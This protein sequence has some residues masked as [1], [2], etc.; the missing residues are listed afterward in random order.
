L[1]R[2]PLVLTKAALS[3]ANTDS[4]SNA[5]TTLRATSVAVVRIYARRV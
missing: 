2:V 5:Q 4:Q 1:R 3:F